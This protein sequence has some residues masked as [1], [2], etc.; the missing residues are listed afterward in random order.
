RHAYEVCAR[1]PTLTCRL[2]AEVIAARLATGGR[3]PSTLTIG[4]RDGEVTVESA[5]VVD[6]T[7]DGA[8]AAFGGAAVEMA[9][10]DELQCPSFIFR[11]GGTE[12]GCAAGFARLKLS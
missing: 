4:G 8:I 7:G 2:D 12:P 10:P 11:V 6:T 1:E 3:D 5:I 9:P